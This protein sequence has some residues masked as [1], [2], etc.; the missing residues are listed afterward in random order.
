M[1]RSSWNKNENLAEE[2]S[3]AGQMRSVPYLREAKGQGGQGDTQG[4]G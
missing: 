4:L 3:Q 2:D 1:R